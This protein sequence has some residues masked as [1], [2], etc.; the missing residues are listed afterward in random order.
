MQFKQIVIF[1]GLILFLSGCMENFRNIDRNEPIV[2]GDKD[3]HGCIGSAGY[4]W[5]EAKQKCLRAW[6]EECPGLVFDQAMT[7]FEECVEAG[8]PIQESLPR[9]CQ[10]AQGEVFVEGEVL[11]QDPIEEDLFSCNEK[12]ECIPFP[13]ECHPRECINKKYEKNYVRPEMCTMMF[14]PQAAYNLE[15]CD[16]IEGKCLNLNL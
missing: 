6:E 2:G 3:E 9:Q 13:S 16:C 15:D 14:D 8:F 12:T 11:M 7:T 5:C 10:N 4:L 1:C